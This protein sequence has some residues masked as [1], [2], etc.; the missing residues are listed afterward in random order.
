MDVYASDDVDLMAETGNEIISASFFTNFLCLS[1]NARELTVY[2]I[3]ARK[4]KSAFIRMST[5]TEK[6]WLYLMID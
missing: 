5:F 1:T 2:C 6:I 4:E 3:T